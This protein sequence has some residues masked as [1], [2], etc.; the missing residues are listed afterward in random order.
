MLLSAFTAKPWRNGFSAFVAFIFR[1][2]ARLMSPRQS[3]TNIGASGR[4]SLSNNSVSS[5]VDVEAHVRV[6]V[7]GADRKGAAA[8]AGKDQ[9]P[10]K[11][12][13][14]ARNSSS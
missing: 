4:N 2:R 13:D 10:A 6:V 12:D 11:P 1:T 3:S 8:A 5:G 7:G 14:A 9:P